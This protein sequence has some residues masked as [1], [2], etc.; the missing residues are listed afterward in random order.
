MS[1]NWNLFQSLICFGYGYGLT[2]SMIWTWLGSRSGYSHYGPYSTQFISIPIRQQHVKAHVLISMGSF[3]VNDWGLSPS[4]KLDPTDN[5][6]S[7]Q[8]NQIWIHIW[9]QP[10]S[11]SFV[12]LHVM[13]QM[14]K[15]K[16]WIRWPTIHFQL[17]TV[18]SCM[19]DIYRWG[20][21]RSAI[22][23]LKK[24]AMLVI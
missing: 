11:S 4:P 20:L 17:G 7:V 15:I 19:D 24:I 18:W 21:R 12:P 1:I 13:D 6:T 8:G 2:V 9:A 5:L 23:L 16:W 3:R 22:V 14:T 10:S